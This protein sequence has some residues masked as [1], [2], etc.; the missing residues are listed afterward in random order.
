MEKKEQLAAMR[1]VRKRVKD[2]FNTDPDAGKSAINGIKRWIEK[3]GGFL[4]YHSKLA[5]DVTIEGHLRAYYDKPGFD[6]Y[7]VYR[8]DV[9]FFDVE[10]NLTHRVMEYERDP[11]L[12]SMVKRT[13]KR[14]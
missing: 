9:M 12:K 10:P 4:N 13:R 14:R 3:E 1:A 5:M 11:K 8:K 2:R 7:D 6:H